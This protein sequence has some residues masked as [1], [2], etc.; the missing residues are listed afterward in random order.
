MHSSVFLCSTSTLHLIFNLPLSKLYVNS[1]LST[2]NAR[3]EIFSTRSPAY[4][5]SAPQNNL[6]TKGTEA[7]ASFN[8][9]SS[10]TITHKDSCL[11]ATTAS[12]DIGA[13]QVEVLD[14]KVDSP[15]NVSKSGRCPSRDGSMHRFQSF[16]QPWNGNGDDTIAGTR[17]T[18]D[19]KSE[20]KVQLIT[21]QERFESSLPNSDVPYA[22]N[23]QAVYAAAHPSTSDFGHASS[24]VDRK[25][26]MDATHINTSPIS[27]AFSVPLQRVD[28]HP[29]STR[30]T[31]DA[32]AF[33]VKEP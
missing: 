17:C 32:I 13:M 15:A 23:V 4:V 33:P 20:T 27:P 26:S 19:V 28:G 30:N 1:L 22:S 29:S 3:N 10:Q 6:S 25:T 5:D 8:T 9:A 14:V 7:T 18:S 2:L 16:L 12:P 11:T 21:V 31:G 24:Y